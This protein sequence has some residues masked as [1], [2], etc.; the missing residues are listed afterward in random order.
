[1]AFARPQLPAGASSPG[2][3]STSTSTTSAGACALGAGS[4]PAG[5]PQSPQTTAHPPTSAPLTPARPSAAPAGLQCRPLHTGACSR[6][7][8]AKGRP[9]QAPPRASMHPLQ[10]AAAYAAALAL[11]HSSGTSAPVIDKP[12]TNFCENNTSVSRSGCGPQLRV[13]P[14]AQQH[15]HDALTAPLLPSSAACVQRLAALPQSVQGSIGRSSTRVCLGTCAAAGVRDKCVRLVGSAGQA[16]T[17]QPAAAAEARLAAKL[18]AA[19]TEA[20]IKD[21]LKVKEKQDKEEKARAEAAAKE[22]VVVLL[23]WRL[24]LQISRHVHLQGLWQQAWRDGGAMRAWVRSSGEGTGGLRRVCRRGLPTC[25]PPP[26]RLR[27]RR[28][29]PS[30]G[31]SATASLPLPTATKPRA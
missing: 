19:K 29:A 4:R 20:S 31:P 15:C 1:M 24:R 7:A 21:M 14:R 11:W 25:G 27:G 18:K 10:E 30:S 26:A 9:L 17:Y 28:A 12:P 6:L 8:R 3:S 2:T 13:A 5:R 22:V 23:L 16:R